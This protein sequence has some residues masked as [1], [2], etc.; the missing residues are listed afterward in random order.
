MWSVQ[1]L[2]HYHVYK[3]LQLLI[4]TTCQNICLLYV[5][6][7]LHIG[8]PPIPFIIHSSGLVACNLFTRT[9]SVLDIGPGQL[10]VKALSD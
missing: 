2:D 4:T 5:P 1:S 9:K 8:Q 6:S 3:V 10:F 7:F